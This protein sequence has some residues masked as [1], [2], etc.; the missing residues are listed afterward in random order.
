MDANGQRF[1]ILSDEQHWRLL[2]DPSALEYDGIRRSLRLASQ[3]RQISFPE[4]EASARERLERIPQTLDEHGNRAYWD[5][6]DR[7]VIATGA[8]AEETLI[9]SLTDD[10]DSLTDLVMGHDGVL[11]MAVSGRVVRKTRR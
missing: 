8:M 1:W 5:E 9:Y 6:G 11:Y 4:A 3:R 7:A 2:G 10:G